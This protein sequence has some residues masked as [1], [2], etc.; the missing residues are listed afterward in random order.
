MMA[1]SIK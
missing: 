1:G